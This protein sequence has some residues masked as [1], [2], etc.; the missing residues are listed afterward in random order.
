MG[1]F[2]EAGFFAFLTGGLG[3]RLDSSLAADEEETLAFTR[4]EWDVPNATSQ[5]S[6]T[7]DSVTG[8]V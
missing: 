3:W 5:L 6:W 4:K 2:S 1:P 7:D 8:C